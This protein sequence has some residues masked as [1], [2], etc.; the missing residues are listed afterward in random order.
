MLIIIVSVELFL[1]RGIRRPASTRGEVAFPSFN[2]AAHVVLPS[3]RRWPK[4]AGR[5]VSAF[6]PRQT[7][8]LPNNS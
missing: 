8:H 6:A 2:N 3:D 1:T 5:S 7:R 4:H